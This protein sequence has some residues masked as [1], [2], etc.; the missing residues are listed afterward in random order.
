M[1]RFSIAFAILLL[2]GM[3]LGTA[4][5][6]YADDPP[7][8]PDLGV[9]IDIDITDGEVQILINGV[10]LGG[11]SRGGGVG[12]ESLSAK[13]GVTKLKKDVAEIEDYLN[14]SATALAKAIQ[15]AQGNEQEINAIEAEI[16]NHIKSRLG[17]QE[18]KV[19]ALESDAS[20][21]LE[22]IEAL[23]ANDGATTAYI[24][25]VRDYLRADYNRKL[26]TIIAVG[27][28]I[29]IGLCIALAILYRRTTIIR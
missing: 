1:K 17:D 21:Q 29:V 13:M 24:T 20:Y 15:I 23:V 12:L 10:K 18:I 6:A 2:A 16:G 25:A 28:A 14:L 9:T 19:A 27:S 8:P 26:T 7:E 3:F 5:V 4:S 11:Y 22:C